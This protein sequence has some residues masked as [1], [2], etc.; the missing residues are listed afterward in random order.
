MYPVAYDRREIRRKLRI[1]E[2]AEATGKADLSAEGIHATNPDRPTTH[3]RN[4]GAH[5][6]RG[7]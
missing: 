5:S 4:A 3:E 7:C 1:I 2:H 6:R